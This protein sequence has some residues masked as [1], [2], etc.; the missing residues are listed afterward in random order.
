MRLA[1]INLGDKFKNEINLLLKI[2]SNIMNDASDI[3][4]DILGGKLTLNQKKQLSELNKSEPFTGLV[5]EITSNSEAWNNFYND[6]FAENSI[7]VEFLNKHKEN[8]CRHAGRVLNAGW[9]LYPR[10]SAE[11]TTSRVKDFPDRADAQSCL[12]IYPAALVFRRPRTPR[13]CSRP[14][15]PAADPA[16][17]GRKNGRKN[18]RLIPIRTQNH[19]ARTAKA[20]RPTGQGAKMLWIFPVSA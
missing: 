6:A 8:S 12:S 4:N 5:S 14:L 18:L 1:Q 9:F 20:P 10:R 11:R 2:N 7:P 16:K 3:S 19:P 15:R 13:T 17:N